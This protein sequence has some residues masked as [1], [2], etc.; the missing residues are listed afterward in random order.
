MTSPTPPLLPSIQKEVLQ[1]FNAHHLPGRVYHSYAKVH[2][3]IEQIQLLAEALELPLTQQK[4]AQIAAYT[5]AMNT[6]NSGSKE[7][8]WIQKWSQAH[9]DVD[10][11][12]VHQTLQSV[13]TNRATTSAAALWSD[14]TNWVRYGEN[15]SEQSA[16]ERLEVEL[17]QEQTY[18]RQEWQALELEKIL[19]LR[20]FTAYAKVHYAPVVAQHIA[21]LKNR[22]NKSKEASASVRANAPFEQLE[23]ASSARG[24]Q[25]FFRTNYRNHI[26]LSAIA[27]NKANIMISVNSILISVLI[28]VL[29][30]RNITETQPEVLMPGVIF[31]VTALASLIFAVLSARPKV[32][33]LNEDQ[34]SLEHIKK[35]IAFFGNFVTLS[36]DQYEA[37]MDEVLRKDDLVYGNMSRDLYFLGKVLSKKYYFLTISYNVFMVGFS[38]SV[39][40]FLIL[41]FLR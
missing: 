37:A 12:V 11:E 15:F 1:A 32:T 25:T 36:L 3:T 27:D 38:V 7:K 34:S 10:A 21:K 30:W 29:T 2:Q 31:L 33:N 5:D 17:L 20:F 9:S 26:N 16:L 40:L 14:A 8:K 6:L 41:L 19:K 35:N 13:R 18:S 28:T 23:L 4:I 24:I 22:L 39:A